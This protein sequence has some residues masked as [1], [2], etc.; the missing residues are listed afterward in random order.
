MAIEVDAR[1]MGCPKPVIMTKN[2]IEEAGEDIII[3]IVDND[4]AVE[5][6]KKL[7]K[8]LNFNV[9]VKEKDSD[10]YLSIFKDGFC[11]EAAKDTVNDIGDWAVLVCDDRMGAGAEELG[12]ILIKGYF[13][14]LTES[15]PYPKAILFMNQGVNLTIEGS[16]SLEHIKMLEDQGVE[17]LSC[18]TCLDFYDLKSKL[19]VGSISNMYTIVEK[20]NEVTKVVRI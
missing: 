4:V 10:F 18:G 19:M 16:E 14:A 8:K 6:V 2:A 1:G 13:Y 3:T 11:V 12:K 17:I 9:E 20:M 15:K 7:A 5:N